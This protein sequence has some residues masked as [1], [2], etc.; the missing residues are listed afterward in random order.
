MVIQLFPPANEKLCPISCYRYGWSTQALQE[1]VHRTVVEAT[2][3]RAALVRR[4]A[5]R[6]GVGAGD[7][8][9]V[10]GRGI[11]LD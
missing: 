10:Y 3:A 2:E 11:D 5:G 6:G 1:S 9:T 4:R 8:G 7:P